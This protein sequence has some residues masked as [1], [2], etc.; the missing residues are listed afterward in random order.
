[1]VNW[2]IP[3]AGWGVGIGFGIASP[4]WASTHTDPEALQI[5]S[6]KVV[7]LLL[8]IGVVALGPTVGSVIGYLG[9][10]SIFYHESTEFLK[11]R[12]SPGRDAP[13]HRAEV[14]TATKDALVGTHALLISLGESIGNLELY[15][16]HKHEVAL[17]AASRA[18]TA[19]GLLQVAR[20]LD[21]HVDD[22]SCIISFS[23]SFPEK[24]PV[25]GHGFRHPL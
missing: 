12:G 24:F 1:L 9:E 21:K 17:K 11:D 7:Q 23:R 10:L 5:T 13:N 15:W 20:M 14:V 19:N 25:F 18:V 4:I 2:H 3:K 22:V 8:S 6:T 16:K